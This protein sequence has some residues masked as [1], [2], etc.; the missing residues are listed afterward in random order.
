MFGRKKKEYAHQVALVMHNIC[1]IV[2]GE[3][4]KSF[5]ATFVDHTEQFRKDNQPAQ[6]TAIAIP[7]SSCETLHDLTRMCQFE[8]TESL[9][10]WKEWFV[11]IVDI[12]LH[13]EPYASSTR[14]M[15]GESYIQKFEKLKKYY[16]RPEAHDGAENES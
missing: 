10:P 3:T 13:D 16:V 5:E 1:P 11:T 2:D 12:L 4:V 7:L 15:V 9:D 14:E 8:E 6:I